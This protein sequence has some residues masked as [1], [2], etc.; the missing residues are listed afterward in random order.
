M[1][2]PL[3]VGDLVAN[4]DINS[5]FTIL[6]PFNSQF[7]FDMFD[8][9]EYLLG[10]KRGDLYLLPL[11]KMRWDA[12]TKLA[13]AFYN[14]LWILVPE[15]KI[16][17]HLENTLG[18]IDTFDDRVDALKAATYNYTLYYL[19]DKVTI[20]DLKGNKCN[21]GS[22]VVTS[23]LH[24]FFMIPA[25]NRFFLGRRPYHSGAAHTG[26]QLDNKSEWRPCAH[27]VFIVA[28]SLICSPKA[29]LLSRRFRGSSN[30]ERDSRT[31]LVLH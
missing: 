4:N 29:W 8:S 17:T 16:L 10:M 18:Q 9:M 28:S 14:G 6:P 2:K 22:T 24:P 5:A 23:T 19:E 7:D 27:Q 31:A 26:F 11:S 30:K 20:T 1:S 21:A 15:R 3:F 25:A 13:E 12:R